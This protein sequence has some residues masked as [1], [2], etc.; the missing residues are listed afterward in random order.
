M[1]SATPIVKYANAK[2]RGNGNGEEDVG[3]EFRQR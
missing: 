1:K 2:R 3:T